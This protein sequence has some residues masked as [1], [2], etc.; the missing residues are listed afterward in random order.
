VRAKIKILIE[1]LIR[2]CIP[3]LPSYFSLFFDISIFRS[4]NY[5]MGRI[6]FYNLRKRKRF[7]TIAELI[8]LSTLRLFGEKRWILI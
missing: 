2:P 8:F 7:Y 5:E 3:K 4:G 1:S 6:D